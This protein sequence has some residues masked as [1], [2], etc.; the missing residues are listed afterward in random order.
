ML[1]LGFSPLNPLEVYTASKPE[2]H[3]T[4]LLG[5]PGSTEQTG[6]EKLQKHLIDALKKI[7]FTFTDYAILTN[8]SDDN[9]A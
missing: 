6:V 5:S 4:D 3:I 9:E 8:L 7:S 1:D 2:M